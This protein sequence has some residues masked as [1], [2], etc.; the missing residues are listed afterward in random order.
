MMLMFTFIVD[1]VRPKTIYDLYQ[2]GMTAREIATQKKMK[3]SDVVD[4]IIFTQARLHLGRKRWTNKDD[5][6]LAKMYK[7]ALDIDI[8]AKNLGRTIGGTKSRLRDIRKWG[9]I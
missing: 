5:K 2:S 9:M 7:E 3:F 1:L 4:Q 6:A 8:I